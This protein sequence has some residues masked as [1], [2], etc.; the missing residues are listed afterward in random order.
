GLD[1][2]AAG[3]VEVPWTAADDERLVRGILFGEDPATMAE[4]APVVVAAAAPFRAPGGGYSLV[5]AFR[6]AAG[7]VPVG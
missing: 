7:R 6:Y 2:L 3:L 5:N 1:V 4:L